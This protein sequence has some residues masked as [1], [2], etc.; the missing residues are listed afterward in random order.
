MSHA[1]VVAKANDLMAP[2]VGSFNASR[3]IEAVYAIDS[4]TDLGMLKPFLQKK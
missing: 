3:L 2:V 1:E 4:L